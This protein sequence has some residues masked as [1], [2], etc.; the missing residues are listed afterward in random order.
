MSTNN[1]FL[2]SSSPFLAAEADYFRIPRSNWERVLL[3]VRQIGANTISTRVMWGWHELRE[4]HLD[5][6]G[7]SAPER[8]LVGFIRL[9]GE[10]GLNLLLKPGPFIDAET[11]GGGIPA[12][13]L[14]KIPEAHARRYDGQLWRHSGSRQ[15]RLSYLH[16]Q[17]LDYSRR[18]LISFSQLCC[19]YQWPQG[20]VIALQIDNE[21]PGDGFIP[22]NQ[23]DKGFDYHFRGD[24]NEFYTQ[25]LW[26]QWLEMRH[27]SLENL[28]AAYG[29][30]VKD[31]SEIPF[32]A[33]WAEPRSTGD[34]RLWMDA[35]RFTDWTFG[36]A[37]RQYSAT[38]VEFGWKIPF[39]QNLSSM[40][41]EES[42]QLVNMGA[43]ASAIGWLGQ[44]VAPEFVRT[45]IID[46]AVSAMG[47]EEY[48]QYA[49]WR[50]KLVKNYNPALPS[51]V[52]AIHSTNDFLLQS[53]FAGGVEA[54]SI[55]ACV[56]SNPEPAAVGAYPTWATNAP[57]RSDGSILR[58]FWNT[59]T[60]FSYLQAG[61]GDYSRSQAPADILLGYS[62]APELAGQWYSWPDFLGPVDGRP[63][64]EKPTGEIARALRGS[65]SGVRS[66]ALACEMVR[67]QIGFDV[68]DIDFVAP[69]QFDTAKILVLPATSIMTRRAQQRLADFLRAGGQIVWIGGQLPILDETLNRCDTLQRAARETSHVWQS[70]EIPVD[71]PERLVQMGYLPR[72]AWSD[73]AEG[74]DVTVR[75][76][77]QETLFIT[78]ANRTPK[79]YE[80]T[81]FYLDLSRQI[82]TLKV[83]VAGPHVS[84]ITIKSRHLYSAVI[85]GQDGAYIRMAGERFA[86]DRGH[87]AIVR[88]GATLIITSADPVKVE[89]S[90]PGGW[91]KPSIWQM[92]L[93][94]QIQAISAVQ[95]K[96]DDLTVDYSVESCGWDTIMVLIN[97]TRKPVELDLQRLFDTQQVYCCS[98]LDKAIDQIQRLASRMAASNESLGGHLPLQ[99]LIA[100]LPDVMDQLEGLANGIKP[101]PGQPMLVESYAERMTQLISA[102]ERPI[103]SLVE[104]LCS[105][106]V[107]LAASQFPVDINWID[108]SLTSVLET[109]SRLE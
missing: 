14:A 70:P 2:D 68:I 57:I 3:R 60:L 76:G 1:W 72:Y 75:Q 77:P 43:L 52:S 74:I 33:V 15:P 17:A 6:T 81:I 78:V 37:L 79:T 59:K 56:Q 106:R 31:Y 12:W 66:L 21:T 82:Q 100:I 16:P 25:M 13:L 92:A 105:V 86:I 42:G 90:R 10:M 102:L 29:Q 46:D 65:D 24:Y 45:P 40:P 44:D 54:A 18:W 39:V 41:C 28:K 30:T 53:M 97:P 107:I 84:F 23:T 55:A 94:G 22:W 73:A 89:A 64:P 93:N 71:W 80:G 7:Q 95:I 11:L 32:P 85:H 34:L 51:F 35:A 108:S 9:A 101:N 61:G 48:V 49:F 63:N 36:Q 83:R 50:S 19:E 20:P 109:L 88:S 62:H 5:F 4:G 58:R 103:E 99:K 104:A 8:D 38:L 91:G 87:A 47:F 26:P 67:R 69:K 96:G 98:I 27:G